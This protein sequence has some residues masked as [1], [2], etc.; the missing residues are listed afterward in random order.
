M[1]LGMEV[2]LGPGHTVLDGKPS[3]PKNGHSVVTAERCLT[4]KPPIFKVQKTK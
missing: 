2:D 4:S 3:P 1:P